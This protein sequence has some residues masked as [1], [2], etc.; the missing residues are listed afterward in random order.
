MTWVIH[1]HTHTDKS[2][3][4]EDTTSGFV[5]EVDYDD[6]DHDTVDHVAE[7]VVDA[8]NRYLPEPELCI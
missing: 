8:L 3:V 6:V 4:V 5:M 7:R 1:P 2:F